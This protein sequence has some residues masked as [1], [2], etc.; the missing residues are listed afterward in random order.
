MKTVCCGRCRSEIPVIPGR[1]IVCPNC[2][3]DFSRTQPTV[4]H[5]STSEYCPRC[6]CPLEIAVD[7]ERLCSVCGWFGDWQETFPVPPPQETF[8]AVI[9]VLQ[10]LEMY[11]NVCRAEQLAEAAFD[12]GKIPDR[13]LQNLRK[14]IQIARQNLVAWFTTLRARLPRVLLLVNGVVPWP[15]DWTERRSD[16]CDL[17]VGLCSCGSLHTEK[18]GWVQSTLQHHDAIIYH[19]EP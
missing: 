9:A 5:V 10:S 6:G 17:L 19:P 12:I 18:E 13:D 14:C 11:R 3:A 7:P 1:P 2:G 16:A 15:D 8:N 4:L